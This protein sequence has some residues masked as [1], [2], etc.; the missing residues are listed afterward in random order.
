MA[1]QPRKPKLRPRRIIERPRLL[2]A[3]DNSNARIRTLVAGSGYGKTTLLEQWASHN[4]RCGWFRALRSAADVAVTAR[5]FASAADTVL[6]GAARRILE[7]LAVTQD[8]EREVSVLA[9]ILAEDLESW[10]ADAFIVVD[11]YHLLAP[12]AACESFI[13]KVV[14][15]TGVRMI[16]ASERRPS[17]AN[18]QR[19]LRGEILEIST[20]TLAMT[21]DEIIE[22][23]GNESASL[24]PALVALVN[25]CPA[26][27]GLASM[28]ARP[29]HIDTTG[30][31]LYDAYAREVCAAVDPS[32][33][34]GL[35]LLAA[36]PLIDREL[37][38]TLLGA[39]RSRHVIDDAL[40]LGLLDERDGRIHLHD[41]LRS[42][43]SSHAGADSK[44]QALEAFPTAWAHYE[45]RNEP[46]AAFELTDRFGVPT[47]LAQVL[48]GSMDELLTGARLSTLEAWVARAGDLIGESPAV[49]IAQAEIA[50]RRG[51]HLTAQALAERASQAE[52]LPPESRYRAYM[53]AG[54]AAHFRLCEE[55]ALVLYEQA[56]RVSPTDSQRRQ[57]QWAQLSAAASLERDTARDLLNQL[58]IPTAVFDAT[59]AVRS[60]DKSLALGIRFGA[61]PPL[62]TAR[63]VEELL[64]TVPDPFARGSFRCMFSYALSLAAEYP[65]ALTVAQEMAQDAAEFRIEF[66]LCYAHLMQ[67]IALAGLRRFDEAFQTLNAAFAHAVRCS[68]P[69]GQQAVYA[70][71]V[72]ALLH[73]GKAAEACALEPPD[74]TDSLPGMRGEVWTSRGLALACIGRLDEAIRFA[75]MGTQTTRAVESTVLAE[76][77]RAIAALKSRSPSRTRDLRR[78]L[79]RAWDAGAVDCIVTSYRASPDLLVALLRD[80]ET[81][82]KAGYIVTRAA[83]QGLATSVGVDLFA[84]VDRASTLS[85][86]EREVYEL[87]CEGLSNREIARRLFISV[88]TVKAHAHHIYDKLG[89]RS[90]AALAVQAARQRAYMPPATTLG[91]TDTGSSIEDG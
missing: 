8:P 57:S 28:V 38:L 56:E 84:S 66:A 87:L 73:E 64:P 24:G 26:V 44:I 81:V 48:A 3:L 33:R 32:L 79:R 89:V 49:M 37:A 43:L 34:V 9:E 25:G 51:R 36:M 19:I 70:G 2:R 14:E 50:L 71:R 69:F 27:A 91:D 76:C 30:E 63:S 16:I 82:E 6:P 22:V 53:T 52:E 11:D 77:I 55:H 58:L 23:T 39:K 88:E 35:E 61:V 68:D 72:R 17:W 86:R 62:A 42:F 74:L 7:R 59:E 80:P 1:A 21:S 12:S 5:K 67:G 47:D 45:R 18:S 29:T 46:D 40:A 10:P 20:V 90:R 78:L 85:A 15:T 13:E 75:T 31:E 54:R 60:A 4:Q 41:L 65:H 83:D